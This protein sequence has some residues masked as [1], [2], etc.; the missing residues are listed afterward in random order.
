MLGLP[1]EIK[2]SFKQKLTVASFKNVKTES[3]KTSGKP[4][5]PPVN[6][7]DPFADLYDKCS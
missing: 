3:G 4:P 2:K 7:P 1:E 6:K 5:I